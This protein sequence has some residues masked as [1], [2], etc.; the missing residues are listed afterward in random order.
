MVKCRVLFEVRTGLL[1]IILTS[2]DPTS[3]Q[4]S[5]PDDGRDR[6]RQEVWNLI[7]SPGR[8]STPRR[9]DWLTDRLS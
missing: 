5:A 9:T 8:G 2:L 4:D 6:K 7:L 3:R 1:N